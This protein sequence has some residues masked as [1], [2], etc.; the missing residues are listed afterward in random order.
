MSATVVFLN[1]HFNLIPLIRGA[2]GRSERF[3]FICSYRRKPDNLL[4]PVKKQSQGPFGLTDETASGLFIQEPSL[5]DKDYARRTL[6]LCSHYK[7]NVVLPSRK[8]VGLAE[9]QQQFGRAE[10]QVILPADANLLTTM[11]DKALF[12]RA[13]AKSGMPIPDYR[14]VN[15]YD[16][17]AVAAAELEQMHDKVCFKPAVSI[18]GHGFRI[19]THDDDSGV[20]RL[21]SGER[22][23]MSY[24]EARCALGSGSF[25]D[26]MVMEVL[27][28]YERSVD[29]LAHDGHLI[30]AIVRRKNS[31][32]TQLLEDNPRVQ[33]LANQLTKHLKLSGL[34]NMQFKDRENGDPYLLEINPRMSGGTPTACLSGVVLPY[35]GIRIAMTTIGT[36]AK[37]LAKMPTPRTGV[38]VYENTIATVTGP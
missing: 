11:D 30:C 34:Y 12:Y 22:T 31:D 8:Y 18:F 27:P 26:L 19:L 25:R 6:E 37:V 15:T 5:N 38:L 23:K 28:G 13:I 35:W 9:A 16:Q 3:K 24:A 10:I 7:V 4:G 36:M 14:I 20:E 32:G 21:F 33:L 1:S 17:L 29:C 2:A